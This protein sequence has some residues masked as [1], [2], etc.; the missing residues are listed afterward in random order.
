MTASGIY[1][2][3]IQ[4]E[5]LFHPSG[6]DQRRPEI[7]WIP[8]GAKKQTAFRLVEKDRTGRS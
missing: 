4:I 6:I 7:Q 8:V 1:A 2:D 5:H 3:R